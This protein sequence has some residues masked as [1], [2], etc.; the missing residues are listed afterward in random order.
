MSFLKGRIEMRGPPAALMQEHKHVFSG[1]DGTSW[2]IN[3]N[4]ALPRSLWKMPLTVLRSTFAG[5]RDWKR[6]GSS[7][8]AGSN[9]H[10]N[11][12]GH[13]N[14][15]V[16]GKTH[17]LST[18]DDYPRGSP[19][20]LSS[21]ITSGMSCSRETDLETVELQTQKRVFKLNRT[22]RVVF[23]FLPC[24]HFPPFFIGGNRGDLSRHLLWLGGL[25]QQR[26]W[27]CKCRPKQWFIF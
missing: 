2:R 11:A 26:F 15:R 7:S 16:H 17:F 3:H 1:S 20:S 8:T 12:S 25:Q 22:K 9:L 27:I 18:E 19:L 24:L 21:S 10:T 4:A 5:K 13:V 14:V 23:L 6:T